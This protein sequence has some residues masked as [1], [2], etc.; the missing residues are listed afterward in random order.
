MSK[1]AKILILPSQA[2]P[3]AAERGLVDPAA[4]E[5]RARWVL[6][7]ILAGALGF[8]VLGSY[9]QGPDETAGLHELTIEARQSLYRRT[10]DEVETLCREPAASSGALRA[11]CVEQARFVQQLPECKTLCMQSAN[12][13]L[14]HSRR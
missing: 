7:A 14:P 8:F 4:G 1:L 5:R 6:L 13:V 9:V 12:A 3:H 11:H 2:R 10:L